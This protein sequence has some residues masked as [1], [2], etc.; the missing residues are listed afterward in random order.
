MEHFLR[1]STNGDTVGHLG[2]DAGK[3]SRIS[4]TARVLHPRRSMTWSQ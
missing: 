3:T 2:F 4:S 1:I